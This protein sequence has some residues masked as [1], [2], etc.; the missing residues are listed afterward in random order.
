[1]PFRQGARRGFTLIEL[2]V[3]IAIIA[4]LIALLLPAVQSAREAA[5]RIQ[6]VNNLKQIGLAMQNYH[7]TNGS[8]PMGDN[9]GPQTSGSLV[10]QNIGPFLAMSQY[11]EQGNVYNSLN[12][13]LFIYIAQNST[14][15]GVGLSAVWCPSDGD[16]VG[17][18]Y[19][20]AAGDGWDDSPIPMCFTSYGASLGTLYYNAGRNPGT[21]LV[22]QNNG[23]FQHAGQPAT[24][25][26]TGTPGTVVSISG[27]TDG[28]SNTILAGE[29]CYTKSTQV[30]GVGWMD[31]NW[32]TTG[33]LGDGGYCAIFPPNF[34]KSPAAASAVP[35][36]MSSGNNYTG[37]A[38]SQHPGGC[39]FAFCDGSVRFIKDTVA[40]WNPLLITYVNRTT[41]YGNVPQNGV[42]QALHTR[43]GG[44]VISADSY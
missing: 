43:A 15:N 14:V 39:N 6:C 16:V 18:R 40:S 27:I 29:K 44:E 12:T 22:A 2:L 11:I 26:G 24:W 23:I 17:K 9:F 13:S 35:N 38:S 20:G 1:M 42:Y 10:R 19:P 34:F 28:T 4:V 37:T 25:P 36:K 32:W 8:F 31:P 30:P 41:P 3:V 5:R 7:D 33:L 21:A